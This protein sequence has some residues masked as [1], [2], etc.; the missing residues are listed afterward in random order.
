MQK[1]HLS[2]KYEQNLMSAKL[3]IDNKFYASSVHC[4][5]YA[6]FQFMLCKINN[7]TKMSFEDISLSMKGKDSHN[8]TKE[9]LLT[10]L[11]KFLITNDLDARQ[12]DVLNH[13]FRKLRRKIDDL[14][15][16]RNESDYQNCEIDEK[17]GLVSLTI[18]ND[19][20][21]KFN[22]YLP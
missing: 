8:G 5:Y 20:I 2:H 13:Q 14:K 6:L 11:R 7:Y 22:E 4:S 17:K 19:V 18:S 21:N 10:L 16:Y 3:L 12:V 15:I 1:T 9:M